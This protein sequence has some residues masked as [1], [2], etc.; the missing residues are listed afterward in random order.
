[1][2]ACLLME[3]LAQWLALQEEMG[4]AT[5]M[6][7]ALIRQGNSSLNVGYLIRRLVHITLKLPITL[8]KSMYL[9]RS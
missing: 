3:R 9:H 1:M 2:A 4:R 6:Q 8:P 5:V 7:R